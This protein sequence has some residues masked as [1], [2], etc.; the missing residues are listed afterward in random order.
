MPTHEEAQDAGRKRD[1]HIGHRLIEGVGAHDGKNEDTRPKDL[2][3]NEC[4]PGEELRSAKPDAEK[5]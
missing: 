3:W 2:N 1:P 4:H 5:Q